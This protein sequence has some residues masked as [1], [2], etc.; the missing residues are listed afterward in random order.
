MEGTLFVVFLAVITT[1]DRPV[2]C[3]AISLRFLLSMYALL[4]KR[5]V[6]NRL[7]TRR[8]FRIDCSDSGVCRTGTAVALKLKKKPTKVKSA[9][10]QKSQT[11]SIFKGA[12]G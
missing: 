7:D 11:S 3:R 12:S 6:P 2:G 10:R 9:T 4:S 5:Q 1:S 8:A